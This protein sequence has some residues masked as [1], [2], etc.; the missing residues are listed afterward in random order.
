[1]SFLRPNA[2]FTL[3]LLL[4]GTSGIVG[5]PAGDFLGTP[6]TKRSK[7]NGNEAEQLQGRC[8]ALQNWAG[9]LLAEHPGVNLWLD[10]SQRVTR[11]QGV[12]VRMQAANLFHE[13]SFVPVFGKPYDQLT[14][15][16]TGK[17]WGYISQCQLK[18]HTALPLKLQPLTEAFEPNCSSCTFGPVILGRLI[19]EIRQAKTELARFRSELDRTPLDAMRL[20]AIGNE[21]APFLQKLWPSETQTFTVA[22]ETAR[23]KAASS[24]L[25]EHMTAR[26]ANAV[27]R[28]GLIAL[29]RLPIEFKLWLDWAD[30]STRDKYLQATTQKVSAI[31]VELMRTENAKLEEIA[32]GQEVLIRQAAWYNEFQQQYREYGNHSS[33]QGLTDRFAQL[34]V[35]TLTKAEPEILRRINLSNSEEAAK[36]VIQAFF[37]LQFD[38]ASPSYSGATLAYNARI[39]GLLKDRAAATEKELEALSRTIEQDQ[40][41][42]EKVDNKLRPF[43]DKYYR[44]LNSSMGAELWDPATLKKM[45]ADVLTRVEACANQISHADS[46]YLAGHY[47]LK[48]DGAKSIAYLEKA[49]EAGR[50]DAPEFLAFLFALGMNDQQSN[51]QRALYWL[52]RSNSDLRERMRPILMSMAALEKRMKAAGADRAEL[53]AERLRLTRQLNE[54]NSR[55]K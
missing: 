11:N 36:A 24:Y 13:T 49:A 41:N 19:A 42:I 21:S 18:P 43:C 27:G 23:Q 55:V 34:R 46:L 48:S 39:R 38:R 10:L 15:E 8:L 3:G 20:V 37:P 1:M 53:S 51:S 35:A 26:T 25:A 40:K 22:Q 44:Y 30:S 5:Q 17:I 14:P 2:Q 33:V 45:P 32:G 29:A 12:I 52:D 4:L 7:A 54:I 6:N 28:T 50:S 16:D 47:Y 31:L 9:K